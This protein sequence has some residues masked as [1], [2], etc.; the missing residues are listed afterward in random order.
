MSTAKGSIYLLHLEPP[1]RHARHYLG[2]A[3]R[4]VTRR[5]GEHLSGQGS[6]LVRAA[7]GAGGS[8]L[9]ARVW[10]GQGRSQ[11][12]RLKSKGTARYCPFCGGTRVGLEHE[13]KPRELPLSVL[14]GPVQDPPF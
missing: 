7:V 4:D 2:W 5:V 8:V 13:P 11:E 14:Q 12:R 9:L 6:P 10:M 3:K 1:Y